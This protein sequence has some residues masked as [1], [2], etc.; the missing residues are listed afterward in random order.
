MKLTLPAYSY[1]HIWKLHVPCFRFKLSRW[2]EW[3]S[4]D[5]RSRS[6]RFFKLED[7]ERFILSRGGLRYLLAC[8]LTCAPESLIFAYN[9]YGKPSLLAPH[10][11]L[12]FNVAHSGAWVIYVVGSQK[13]L[14]VDVEQITL[15]TRLGGFQTRLDGLIEYC[16]T[17]NEQAILPTSHFEKLESFFKY[18]TVKEAHLKA[19]GL[20][21]SYPMIDVEI[22][23]L[24]EPKLVIPAK[25]NK[26]PTDWTVKLWS[27]ANDTIA[28][29]CVGQLSSQ[30][31]I[32]SFP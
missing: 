17:P 14:G 22:A 30:V 25:I 15:R 24:P 6:Q 5:E 3:L 19:I 31:I 10:D 2:F 9:S 20:G 8:Y 21:L 16:L 28:A 18:W 7:R 23:W 26:A 12:Y 29:V 4:Y 1:A 27:P 32:R 11:S 13:F